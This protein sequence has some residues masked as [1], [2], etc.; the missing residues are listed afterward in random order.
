MK[1]SPLNLLD[2][3]VTELF[4]AVSNTFDLQKPVKLAFEDLSVDRQLIRRDDKKSGAWQLTMRVHLAAAPEK[5][6]PYQVTLVLVGFFEVAPN[7]NPD[8]VETLIKV[9]GGSML[10]GAA[11]QVIRSATGQGPYSP[12]LLPAVSFYPPKQTPPTVETK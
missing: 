8:M 11:R 9:T 1:A 12:L 7:Y 3:Y 6:A 5:N 2:Y 10:Y 4:V